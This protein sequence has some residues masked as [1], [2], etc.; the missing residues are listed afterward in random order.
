MQRYD[1]IVLG[2]RNILNFAVKFNVDRFLL[3]SSGGVYGKLLKG[4]YWLMK[5]TMAA[6]STGRSNV[7]G[8]AKREAE[9]LC[10]LY[11]E[12]YGLDYVVARC[13][14]LLSRICY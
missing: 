14:A 3:T 5:T 12:T 11:K 13:F 2:T 8:V 4:M 1:Q 9:L 7:Y 6:R 10:A